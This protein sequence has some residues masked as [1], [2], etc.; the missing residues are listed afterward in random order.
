MN[1][2]QN[3]ILLCD[4]PVRGAVLCVISPTA[5]L[6]SDIL[7]NVSLMSVFKTNVVLLNGVAPYNIVQDTKFYMGLRWD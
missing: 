4:I 5:F 6:P 2:M 7:L 3:V 1:V